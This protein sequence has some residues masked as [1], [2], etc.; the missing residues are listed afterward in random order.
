MSELRCDGCSK[1]IVMDV[2]QL[3]NFERAILAKKKQGE[4]V[5]CETCWLNVRICPFRSNTDTDVPCIK[6]RCAL[7]LGRRCGLVEKPIELGR[8]NES[9]AWDADTRSME[10]TLDGGDPVALEPR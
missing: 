7:W 4:K 2:E 10:R 1:V 6:G 8:L 3:N 9:I 5:Y